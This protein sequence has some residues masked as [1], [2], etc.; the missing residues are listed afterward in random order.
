MAQGQDLRDLYAASYDRLVATVG[1]ICGDRHEAEEAVQEGFVRLLGN[2][3][4]VSRYDDPESWVRMV[5]VRQVS[6]RRR[7]ALNG[8]KATLRLGP[9][10]DVPE[11]TGAAVDIER[12]LADLPLA[13]RAVIVLHRLGLDPG[14]IA[15][16]LGV[17]IGTVKSRLARARAALTTMLREDNRDV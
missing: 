6:N 8:L 3:E 16:A 1:A 13:Q 5:A 9:P 10:P 14:A 11:T 17:P 7:K 15:D 12:A 2:W 4:Q